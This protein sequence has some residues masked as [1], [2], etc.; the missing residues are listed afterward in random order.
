MKIK[1]SAEPG[2]AQVHIHV[3]GEYVGTI[4]WGNPPDETSACE[5]LRIAGYSAA[6]AYHEFFPRSVA[7]S[8]GIVRQPIEIETVNDD[9]DQVFRSTRVVGDYEHHSILVSFPHEEWKRL[10]TAHSE[11][12]KQRIEQ[13]EQPLDLINFLKWAALQSSRRLRRDHRARERAIQKE[14]QEF[15]G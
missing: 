10:T 1:L 14:W 15:E 3:D 4:R 6:E 2:S 8:G 13:H 11:L 9:Y 12:V 5:A 7:F